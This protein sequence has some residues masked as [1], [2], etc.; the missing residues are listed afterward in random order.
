[1]WM[2]AFAAACGGEAPPSDRAGTPADDTASPVVRIGENDRVLLEIVAGKTPEN[3]YWNLNGLFGGEGRIRVPLGAEIEVDFR[4]DDPA[5]THS[6]GVTTWAE[7]FPA[8]FAPIEPAFP[9]AMLNEAESDAG[10]LPPDGRSVFRFRASEEGRY[11]VV[12][13]VPG[14]AAVGM[15]IPFEVVE[16]LPEPVIEH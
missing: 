10:G 4:N 6:L 13:F 7:P 14:H 1:M 8:D 16:G 2:T 3:S 11:A 9:G 12:C 15:F 5:M